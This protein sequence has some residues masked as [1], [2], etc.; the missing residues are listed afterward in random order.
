MTGWF[1]FWFWN[2]RLTADEIRWQIGQ[3]AEQRVDG[4]LICARQGLQ[5][6]YLADAFFEF[7]AIAVEE[8]ERLG[9][10]VV[11]YDEL[12]YPS[13]A[14]GGE[15]LLGNP[16]FCAT[17]LVQRAFDVS[18][19]EISLP[20]PAGKILGCVACPVATDGIVDWSRQIDLMS[21]VGIVQV[22][23][24]YQQTGLTA[25]NR[26]R[27]FTGAPT[28][29]LEATLPAGEHRVFVSAQVL[30][31][32]HKYYGHFVD[33]LNPAAMAAFI[34]LTH[35]R[36]HARL[37]KHFGKTI[38]AIFTDETAPNWTDRL[39]DEFEKRCGY[40]LPPMLPALQDVSNPRHGAVRADLHRVRYE[41]FVESYDQPISRWCRKHGIQYWGEKPSLRLEQLTHF[42]VPGCDVG[43]TKVGAPLAADLLGPG[44]R[45]NAKAVASA[46]YFY[47]KPAALCEAFH[48][49]GW[50]ATLADL[51]RIADG[52][53]L[54]GVTCIVPH[55]FYYSTH[56]LRKHDAP[57]SLFFQ[58]PWWPL[59]G[60][61]HE[62]TSV[63]MEA[64][65][66]T[67]S[68]A[69]VLLLDPS[70]AVPT[71]AQ[72]AEFARVQATLMKRHIEFL[73][74][75]TDVP[76]PERS[77]T[78]TVVVP[79]IPAN[80]MT[81]K[82]LA[83]WEQSGGKV[84]RLAERF[85][86]SVFDEVDRLNDLRVTDGAADDVWIATRFGIE[87]PEPL[88]LLLNVSKQSVT[89]ES[90]D[91]RHRLAA[92][93]MRIVRGPFLAAPPTQQIKLEKMRMAVKTLAPNLLRFGRWNMTV[94]GTTAAVSPAPIINQLIEAKVAFVPGIRQ[95]FGAP[96]E[97][98]LPTLAVSYA[99]EFE[100]AGFAGPVEL[101]I[102]P[103]S[104]AADGW[105]IRLNAGPGRGANDFHQTRAGVRGTLGA[106]ITADLRP[107][108]NRIELE[109]ETAAPDGGLLNP[110]Y[111]AG[112]FGVT[113]SPLSIADR[114]DAGVFERYNENGLP[115]YSGVVEYRTTFVA[116]GV[117][118]MIELDMGAGFEEAC[119]VSVNDGAWQAMPWRP[120]VFQAVRAGENDLVI[121]VH[122]TLI[123]AFEGQSFDTDSHAYVTVESEQDQQS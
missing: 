98:R 5:Q 20:L 70:P 21:S 84:V 93:E 7:A 67:R 60:K 87:I 102:E 109:L 57:P 117:N 2:D 123:R 85:E 101:L 95:S 105:S 63:V 52:L 42:D 120:Y 100:N 55:A 106:N 18:G 19:G 59:F 56:G 80:S 39:P 30:V 76:N 41:L 112:D 118:T 47:D 119:E 23:S 74:C 122:T 108:T 33:P 54:L 26:K 81:E 92:G 64:M 73:I 114:R 24:V 90:D 96:A 6:P 16:Q 88:V 9:L 86:E 97:L 46:A 116:D 94:L 28:P 78:R 37:G 44:L 36:W 8:A 4:F 3:M 104:I 89:V 48:S 61:L 25:Y 14:A 111:L 110:L 72:W 50:G 17:E 77:G 29:V 115:F 10:I 121:R 27:F 45:M 12:P 1:P 32:H 31:E 51:K 43:H 40:A 82:W 113:L 58:M 91:V 38:R 65:K 79:P 34:R 107:G 75:G 62:H 11:I 69:D 35:D 68:H 103:N 15:V 66:G 22:E 13:G 99:V 53:L 49:L 83:S 71:T